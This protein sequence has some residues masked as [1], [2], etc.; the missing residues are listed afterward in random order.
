MTEAFNADK[1]PSK[2]NL[3]VGAYRDDNG[4]PVVL[5]SVLTASKRILETNMNNEY[6][7]IGGTPSFCLNSI[8][9]ALGADNKVI[10]DK[11]YATLQALSGTGSLRL[12]GQYISRCVLEHPLVI[13]NCPIKFLSFPY[14]SLC[15]IAH[16]FTSLHFMVTQSCCLGTVVVAASR[17][18]RSRPCTCPTRPGPTT[19]RSLATAAWR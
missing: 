16:L 14:H 5:P 6:G 8:K 19:S 13:F 15:N 7:P 9:L 4:K 17:V 2:L 10:A 3:G 18:P 11:S 12:A 1:S